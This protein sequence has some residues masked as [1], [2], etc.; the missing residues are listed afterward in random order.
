MK[1]LWNQFFYEPIYNFLIF[2]VDLLPGHSLGLAI[3]LLTIII[4]LILLLPSQKSIKAQKNMQVIQ[5]EMAKIKEKYKSNP[6]LQSQ[7]T[8]ELYKKHKVNPF[9]SCL[10]LLFQFPILI[11]L[12]WV[13]KNIPN[14]Q[15]NMELVKNATDATDP[16]VLL[17]AKEFIDAQVGSLYASFKGFD[18]SIIYTKFLG[19]DLVHKNFISK[20][21]LPFI[22]GSLQF[23][24]MYR[25]QARKKKEGVKA[26]SKKKKEGLNPEGMQSTMMYFMPVMIAFFASAYPAGLSLYWAVSTSFSIVQQESVLHLKK[27]KTNTKSKKA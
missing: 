7:K 25:L 27:S 18:F 1:A 23:I 26:K 12:F 6:Q 3:I 19:F 8:M 14:L 21:I 15:I 20:Y 24:Q 9:G 11:A 2:I 13:C 5:P 22:V 17:K 10:P 16:E 4:K